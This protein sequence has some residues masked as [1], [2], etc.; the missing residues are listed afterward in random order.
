M[1]WFIGVS[2]KNSIDIMVEATAVNTI[3][4]T[5]LESCHS[6][7]GVVFFDGDADGASLDLCG[8]PLAVVEHCWSSSLLVTVILGCARGPV[9]AGVCEL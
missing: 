1:Y 7:S 6:S 2:V 8:A 9:T 5:C 4:F 3:E